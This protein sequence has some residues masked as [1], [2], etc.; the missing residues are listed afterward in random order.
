MS[1]PAWVEAGRAAWPELAAKVSPDE[2]AAWGA[3]RGAG[4]GAPGP[5]LMLACACARGLPEALAAFD[6]T[7]LA[8]VGAFVARID[9]SAPFADEVRQSARALLFSGD[10]KIGDYAGRGP[11]EGWLRVVVTRLALR[12]KTRA[13]EVATPDPHAAG[14]DPEL[15]FIKQR[16]RGAI[17]RALEQALSSL[18]PRER[19]ALKLYYVDGLTLEQIGAIYRVHASTVWRRIAASQAQV[20]DALRAR[21]AAELKI[22]GEELDSLIGLVRSRIELSLPGLLRSAAAG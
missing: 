15:S 21:A 3:A 13:R 1:R 5:D 19:A 17:A 22:D 14:G 8:K 18:P 2:L 6:R 9:G 4:E 12:L 7:L 16:Y 10:G 20:L 11:L